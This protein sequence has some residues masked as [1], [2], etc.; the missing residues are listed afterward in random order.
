MKKCV[1]FTHD[2]VWPILSTPAPQHG[3]YCKKNKTRQVLLYLEND[4]DTGLGL[5]HQ[6]QPFPAEQP[7]QFT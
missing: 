5:K 3:Q 6:V 1:N 4:M 2:T 7:W